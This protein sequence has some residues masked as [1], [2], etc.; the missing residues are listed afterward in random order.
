MSRMRRRPLPGVLALVMAWTSGCSM[1]GTGTGRVDTF[2]LK[3]EPGALDDTLGRR[4]AGWTAEPT[5]PDPA[6]LAAAKAGC[7]DSFSADQRDLI[8]TGA[9][10]QDQRGPDGAAFLWTG[11]STAYCFIGRA[12]DGNLQSPFGAWRE[13]ALGG[14]LALE[15][16]EPGPPAM[17]TGAVDPAAAAVEIE[18]TSGLKLRATIGDGRFVAWWPGVDP[19]V[20][21]WS[22]AADGTPIQ[23]MEPAR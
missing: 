17:V 23:G 11:D 13:V 5:T 12:P 3:G 4:P 9:L 19:W 1:L 18:T 8:A 20:A 21:V 6:F 7:N 16:I 22:L 14:S 2:T 15:G 10:L